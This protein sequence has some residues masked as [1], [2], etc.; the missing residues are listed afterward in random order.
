MP[1]HAR[2]LMTAQPLTLAPGATF[3]E[4]QHLFVEAQIHC[5]PIVDAA[6]TV[7][8]I[9]SASDLLRA[10]DQE[11]DEDVDPN[12]PVDDLGD[13]SERLRT[14]TARE[15]ATPEPIWVSPDAPIDQVARRMREEG[16]HGVLV[17][18]EGRLAGVLTTFDLLHA[19]R[20]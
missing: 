17:G 3:L 4:I 20:T 10:L 19:V 18:S 14:L 6:G 16:I 9:V 1:L 11:C 8:G 15:L 5:A 13:L 7:L 12:E 2:D